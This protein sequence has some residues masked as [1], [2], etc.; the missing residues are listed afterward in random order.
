MKN[1]VKIQSH[2]STLGTRIRNSKMMM[3]EIKASVMQVPG[4]VMSEELVGLL[5]MFGDNSE[6]IEKNFFNIRH[7]LE[8]Y[9]QKEKT[10]IREV[11]AKANMVIT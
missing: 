9:K 3:P 7:Q 10:A 6:S 8:E 1:L 5:N 2:L 4:R 11:K